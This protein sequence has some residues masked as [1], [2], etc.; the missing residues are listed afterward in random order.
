MP[1]GA[2][3]TMPEAAG[4]ADFVLD[5]NGIIVQV[6]ATGENARLAAGIAEGEPISQFVHSDDR[7]FFAFCRHWAMH[8]PSSAASTPPTIR[9]RWARTNGFHSR[10][11]A[12]LLPESAETIR[13]RITRDEA[14]QAKRT[15]EQLKRVVENSLQGIVVRTNKDILFMNDAFATLIGYDSAKHLMA[16]MSG[17]GANGGIHPD[18][19]EMIRERV[20]ARTAG[21]EQI[22][23]YEF[24]MMHRSG[25]YRWVDTLAALVEWDGQKASLSW[26]T[27]IT[28]RKAMEAEL[29][30]SKEAAEYASRTKTEF[31]AHMSH[32]LRTPLNAIIGFAE[33][34]K[35][36][37]FGK[38]GQQ[39]YV[40]YAKDIHRS[41]EHLLDLINDILDLSKLEAGK[42]E[43]RE[44]EVILPEIVTHCCT[45]VRSKAQQGHVKVV[46]DIPVNLPHLQADERAV[47]QILLN[48]L[49]NAIKFTPAHGVV[50]L[51]AL[52]DGDN[53]LRV[54]VTDTGIG[55]KPED[56][57]IALM[58]FGQID[59]KI[60][61]ETKGTGLGL[62]ICKSLLELHGGD[63][64]IESELGKGTTVL[65]I[66]PPHRLIK[67]AA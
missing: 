20:R 25:G 3:T 36:E 44:A 5:R 33:V 54:A 42:L 29:V 6:E 61:R 27:D 50:R 17:L 30:Q 13:V 9:V 43:L 53:S 65:A 46:T 14:E 2:N 12:T 63:L 10:V 26:M 39:K 7:Q 15:A 28:D 37:M 56:I 1:S 16:E 64:R 62:P 60:A 31:L 35:G 45:L 51:R 22:S 58:P 52:V 47:K 8:A 32:E 19:V 24:R 48:F 21:E 59:S 18:D 49:S 34:I 41:G 67:T 4:S 40:D 66:F 11:D 57:E 55:M 23:H 38:A